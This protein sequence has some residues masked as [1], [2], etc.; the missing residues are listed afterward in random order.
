MLI[1]RPPHPIS[2]FEA[3]LKGINQL[4][5]TVP[6][7]DTLS[8]AID[9]AKKWNDSAQEVQVIMRPIL[10]CMDIYYYA[11]KRLLTNTHTMAY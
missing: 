10:T 11:C 1:Y 6:L 4:P 3:Q 9:E 7:A 2:F 5:V 8:L